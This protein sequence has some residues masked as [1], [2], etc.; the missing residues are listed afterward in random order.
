ML[1]NLNQGRHHSSSL[2]SVCGQKHGK[3]RA[4]TFVE[5]L[6]S[7][8]IFAFVMLVGS[9][10]AN[11]Q[12]AV[13]SEQA[14]ARFG[15]H[16][17]V[18]FGGKEGLYASHMPMFHAPHDFQVIIR[19]HLADRKV[20]QQLRQRLTRTPTLWSLDPEDFDLLR[21]EPHHAQGLREFKAQLFEGHF[22]R[23][24][25]KHFAEQKVVIEEVL[26]FQVLLPQAKKQT[27]GRYRLIGKGSEQFLIKEIDRRPDFDV[28]IALGNKAKDIQSKGLLLP[29]DDL[30]L[31]SSLTSL[32]GK[33]VGSAKILY[34]ETGDLE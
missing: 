4:G 7:R 10:T 5:S 20:D 24:G 22:E 9:L 12:Q 8:W 19:F 15:K 30:T 16:G 34:F 27:E 23:D 14:T 3:S 1:K 11:A 29:S 21:L 13:N 6:V 32:I 33:K 31:P 25:K 28:V 26:L 2:A 18:V 17:M